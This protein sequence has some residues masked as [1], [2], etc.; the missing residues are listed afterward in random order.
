MVLKNGGN[1]WAWGYNWDGQLG[2]GTTMDRSTPVQVKDPSD[3]T[4]FLTGVV[5]ISGG[6]GHTV[7]LKNDGN[8]WAWG[9]NW[10]GQAGTGYHTDRNT[11]VKTLSLTG[12]V[13]IAAGADSLHTVAMKGDKTVW[14]WG[15]NNFGQL[16]DGTVVQRTTPVQVK[17]PSDPTNFLTDIMAIAEGEYHTVALRNDGH[18]RAWGANWLGQL[19][20]GT[21]ADSSTPVQAS[22]LGGVAAI[23]AGEA[24]TLA[25][26]I[27]GTVWAWGYN[28]SGQLGDGTNT[29]SSTP[30]QVKDPSDLTTFLTGVAAIAAGAAHSVALKNGAVWAWGDNRFG[31]LGDGTTT[32]STTPV[33]VSSLSGITAVAG[34]F[35][36]TV[37][38]RNDG[39]VWTWGDNEYGQLGDGTTI[40]SSIPV[41]VL[42]LSGVAAIAAAY[43]HTVALKNDGT[44]W[45]WGWNGTYQLGDGTYADSTTP[46]QVKDPSDPSIFLTGVTAIA[47]GQY[48]TVA[49]KNDTTVWAWGDN[50]QGQLGTDTSIPAFLP[51]WL[52]SISGPL[53]SNFVSSKRPGPNIRSLFNGRPD[54][55][56][57]TPAFTC[58]GPGRA[59]TNTRG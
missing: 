16:G 31:Q 45:A 26:K 55:N 37:A 21:Y 47:A 52:G 29:G 7:A 32:D 19:G 38:L 56:W 13:A 10:S 58:G 1:V 17:D 3:P 49:L 15:S 22:S 57:T 39:T 27:D 43:G 34:G 40:N 50:A 25:L 28:G 20:D 36:H 23:A 48:H 42:S 53:R 12:V 8:V 14:A 18:V 33:H 51:R 30:I 4:T 11:P 54:P 9:A 46:L 59:K 24:H 35:F 2:D 41:Q 44:V 5:C 6:S